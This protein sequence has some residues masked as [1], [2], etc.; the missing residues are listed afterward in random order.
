MSADLVSNQ[1]ITAMPESAAPTPAEIEY[2]NL[3][4][5]VAD[6]VALTVELVDEHAIRVLEDANTA[7]NWEHVGDMKHVRQIV[8]QLVNF[9]SDDDI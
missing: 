7:P 1:H 2:R 8:K 4:A 9:L 5:E 6:L 3:Y